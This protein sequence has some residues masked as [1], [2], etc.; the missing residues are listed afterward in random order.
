MAT[1]YTYPIVDGDGITPRQF[2]LTCARAF[3][4]AIQQRDG[5]HDTPLKTVVEPSDYHE[6]ELARAEIKLHELQLMAA[7]DISGAAAVALCAAR[8]C[9]KERV[10]ERARSTKRFKDM[11]AA[12]RQW[13]P[14]TDGHAGLKKFAIEQIEMSIDTYDIDAVDVTAYDPAVWH[15]AE[16]ERA[17][18]SVAHHRESRD[19]EITHCAEKTEWLTTF[20]ASLPGDE[21]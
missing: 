17:T 6:R 8:T 9:R 18:R 16:I 20:V 4:A 21:S 19:E 1:G 5:S 3:G 13:E 12:V 2:L 14:P 15:A 10:T 11:L 7:I